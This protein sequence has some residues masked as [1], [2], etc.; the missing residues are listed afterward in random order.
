M[1]P[2]DTLYGYTEQTGASGGTLYYTSEAYDVTS[3]AYS[4][5]NI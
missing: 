2:R 1:N 5:I 3:G 4:W